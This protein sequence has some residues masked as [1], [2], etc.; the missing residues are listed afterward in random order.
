MFCNHL[1]KLLQKTWH[2]S[3]RRIACHLLYHL[4][5]LSQKTWHQSKRR[6]A[7]SR[8][9][10]APFLERISYGLGQRYHYFDEISWLFETTRQHFRPRYVV[11]AIAEL[12]RTI[13]RFHQNNDNVVQAMRTFRQNCQP[14]I[15][16]EISGQMSEMEIRSKR[17]ASCRRLIAYHLLNHLASLL[18]K[19]LRGQCSSAVGNSPHFSNE[20]PSRILE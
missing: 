2:Q 13:T 18:Q 5:N 20:Y 16:V 12:S 17:G 7:C 10:L 19:S 11:L 15:Q 3:N 9:Q 1:A 8:R 14:R 6:I 4:A